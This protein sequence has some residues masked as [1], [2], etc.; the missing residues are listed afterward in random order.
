[1]NS[2]IAVMNGAERSFGG[3]HGS[4]TYR[5][6]D[7]TADRKQSTPRTQGKIVL[8]LVSLVSFVLLQ[9]R[10]RQ[11]QRDLALRHETRL[12]R[13]RPPGKTASAG[14]PRAEL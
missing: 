13:P 2:Q 12:N 8:V 1:M 10:D 9:R 5:F 11:S 14:V 4:G 3:G 7:S 6:A